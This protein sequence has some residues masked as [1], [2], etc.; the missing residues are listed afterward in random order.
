M[1]TATSSI[2]SPAAASARSGRDL[3]KLR[4]T[5]GLSLSTVATEMATNHQ[6]LRRWETGVLPLSD[7]EKLQ[8]WQAALQT[9][10]ERR[11]LLLAAQGFRPGDLSLSLQ[12][13]FRQLQVPSQSPVAS[14]AG[15]SFS[16]TSTSVG[17]ADCCGMPVLTTTTAQ[18]DAH[19]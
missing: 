8:R 18:G 19:R 6:S 2:T 9:L 15:G 16:A 10:A 12:Q 11:F 1:A 13:A 14:V 4:I 7:P 3:A 17:D 5:L